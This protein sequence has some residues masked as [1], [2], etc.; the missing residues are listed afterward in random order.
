[1]CACVCVCVCVCEREKE[2]ESESRE[3]ERER[4]DDDDVDVCL[5]ASALPHVSVRLFFFTGISPSRRPS[6]GEIFCNRRR[7]RRNEISDVNGVFIFFIPHCVTQ[8]QLMSC[9][10]SPY[11]LNWI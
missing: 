10:L 8:T 5:T 7:R 2:R 11:V 6:A 4:H 1:M 3:K 9:D